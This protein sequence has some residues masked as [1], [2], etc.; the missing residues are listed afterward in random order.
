MKQSY[1]D[2]AEWIQ[3]EVNR[4][5]TETMPARW[6]PDRGSVWHP[7][8]D[9]YETDDS[10]VVIVEIA[11]LKKGDYELTLS[12]RTLTVRGQ[13][14]DPADKLFYHQMEIRYGEFRTQVY[15]PWPLRDT[16][17]EIEATY[18]DGLLRVVLG[19]A[20]PRRVP[21]KHDRE[22]KEHEKR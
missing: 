19:K 21:V 15:L 17:Q 5:L 9:V 14:Q 4:V 22:E 11:G 18:E 10:V 16:D 7:P 8:T 12:N 3:A 1:D 20:Q 2:E 6:R 13:R